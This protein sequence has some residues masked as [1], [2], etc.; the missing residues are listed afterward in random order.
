[1]SNK[2]HSEEIL[3]HEAAHVLVAWYSP[4]FTRVNRV[5]CTY[6]DSGVM[7]ANFH[8]NSPPFEWDHLS[9]TLA[10]LAGALSRFDTVR[11]EG[12]EPDLSEAFRIAEWLTLNSADPETAMIWDFKEGT[13]A[14]PFQRMLKRRQTPQV[15]R[16]MRI[17]YWRANE[18]I[19]AHRTA[20]IVLITLLRKHRTLSMKELYSILGEPTVMD[21]ESVTLIKRMY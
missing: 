13:S 4:F 17:G 2:C 12:N 5:V 20:F 6:R 16:L 8:F 18:I 3:A 9:V 21:E 1:M 19:R 7:S 10:G 15:I 14:P 11:L